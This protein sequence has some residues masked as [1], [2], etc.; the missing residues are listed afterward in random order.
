MDGGGWRQTRTDTAHDTVTGLPTEVDDQGDTARQDD[1]L[2]TTTTYAV[3]D[4]AWI[5]DLP[6]RVETVAARCSATPARPDGIVS[7]V[8]TFYDGGA[9]G[10]A[11][12]KGDPTRVE[13]IA[14]HDGTGATY[15]PS[16]RTT[17][18][19]Y[20][21]VTAVTDAAGHTTTTAYTETAG[22]TTRTVT[23]GP[24]ITPGDPS[25]AH[26]TTETLDPAH[27]RATARTDPAG[28]TTNLTH[29]ALGRLTKVWLP[30]RATTDTPDI[31]HAYQV[32]EGK[33]G[34]VTTRT[35][36]PSGGRRVTQQ[37]F[38][39]LQRPAA[40]P[41]PSG[42]TPTRPQGRGTSSARSPRPVARTPAPRH[43]TTT[44]PAA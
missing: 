44:L 37:L 38:D 40:R 19:A 9:F 3:N 8:R 26:V 36:T 13:K 16:V 10:A 25:S 20:G 43:S 7:D 35:L 33:I 42:P 31:E 22:L 34:A 18:D 23:T 28:R 30:G 2:C 4:A 15:V 14:A 5:R 21:R 39:A 29:D 12:S 11:P 27:G 17:Y 32:A 1:D 6:A 41:T 24:P